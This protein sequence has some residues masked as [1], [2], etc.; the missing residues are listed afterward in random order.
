MYISGY[1]K[2]ELNEGETN[3]DPEYGGFS[4]LLVNNGDNTWTDQSEASGVYR[5]HNTFLAVFVDL[6]N[7]QYGDLVVAQDTGVVEIWRNQGDTTFERMPNPTDYSFPMGIGAGDIDND[8]LV[9]LYFSNVG[10]TLPPSALRGN[11]PEDKTFNNLYMLLKNNGS[12]GFTDIAKE[13]NAASYG[14]G[15]GTVIADFNN[16][17]RM[18]LYFAQNYARFPAVKL[19][20][21]YPGR[22]LQQYPDGKFQAVEGTAGISNQNFGITQVVSDFNQDGWP[23]MVL[24]NLN[25]PARAFLNAGGKAGS[26]GTPPR[27]WL[28]V[29]LPNNAAWLNTRVTVTT[30]DGQELT[31]QQFASEGF[32]SDQTDAVFFGLGAQNG[33]VKVRVQPPGRDAQTFDDVSVNTTLKVQ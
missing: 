1:I 11:L 21:R 31:R 22:L 29:R 30:A 4:H 32:C 26:D 13:A 3:F 12:F 25:G 17:G 24:G 27:N 14:F 7:D 28:T 8:G 5:Q 16:D 15:W 23:D 33:P 9:D 18:D 10:N 2:L 6:D 20:E 19:L